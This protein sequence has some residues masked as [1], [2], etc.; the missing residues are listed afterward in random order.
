MFQKATRK[1]HG[2]LLIDL[3][4]CTPDENRLQTDVFKDSENTFK[5]HTSQ[6]YSHLDTRHR[7]VNMSG[8]HSHLLH[9]TSAG[10][11]SIDKNR[12]QLTMN[13]F[14]DCLDCGALFVS[15]LDLQRH[16]KGH[17]PEM[18]NDKPPLKKMKTSESDDEDVEL[19]DDSSFDFLIQDVF[20]AY[21]DQYQ[22][23][24]DELMMEGMSRRQATGEVTERFQPLYLKALMKK[25][26]EFLMHMCSMK[27][28][29]LHRK[30][31]ETADD[32]EEE[33]YGREKA[34]HKAIRA[35][36]LLFEDLLED[37][38][39]EDESSD[40]ESDEQDDD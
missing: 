15:P 30:I 20:E 13:M 10:Y 1:P 26:E 22:T 31:M 28:S 23:E 3:K 18:Q 12:S 25:Y 21:D 38:E 35:N 14:V 8:N 6:C 33:G 5:E 2:Y 17:C 24:V 16:I 11:P 27:R 34:L 29:P 37:V 19:L 39:T 4:Q 32:F 40:D 36:K 9:N 7:T